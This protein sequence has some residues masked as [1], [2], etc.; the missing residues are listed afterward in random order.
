MPESLNLVRTCSADLQAP[1]GV[2]AVLGNHDLDTNA[3]QVTDVLQS[4]AIPVLRNR[5]V[6]IER[7]GKRLWFAGVDDVLEG[8]PDLQLAL[9]G[10][11]RAD[12]V[13]LLSHEPDWADHVGSL[14]S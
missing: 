13:V 2:L 14:S 1:S 4:H 6:V 12:P 5:S 10:V 7:E 3:A 8:S 9:R 11:P